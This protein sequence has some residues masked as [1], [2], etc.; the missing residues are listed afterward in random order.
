MITQAIIPPILAYG[1]ECYPNCPQYVVNNLESAFKQIVYSIFEI[2]AKT[3]YS[4][5]LLEL[6]FMRMKHVL[7]KLQ[8]S[9]MSEVVW[10]LKG[11]TVN[12]VILE[13]YELSLIH[14]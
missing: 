9:Y 3:K 10:E 12:A 1:A 14:I 2:S 8:I 7:A 5:V 13:E 4:S 11:T 6:G